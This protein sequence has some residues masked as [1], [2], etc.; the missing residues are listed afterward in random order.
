MI[1]AAAN[2]L[3][4]WKAAP[5]QIIPS[6]RRS[7]TTPVAPITDTCTC[8]ICALQ[9]LQFHLGLL[10][11]SKFQEAFSGLES[12]GEGVGHLP[13]HASL[14]GHRKALCEGGR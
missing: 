7:P 6:T 4:L 1:A 11:I 14:F 13:E 2:A 5:P 12:S 9:V 8:P 3:V 10:G